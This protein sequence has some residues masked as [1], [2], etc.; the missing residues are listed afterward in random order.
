MFGVT[1]SPYLLSATILHHLNNYKNDETADLLRNSFYVDNCIVSVQSR[2]KMEHFM[3]EAKRIMLEG[4]FELRCWVT[5]PVIS[6]EEVVTTSI[7]G[8]MWDPR[9]D[10]LFSKPM[11]PKSEITKR[12]LL[13]VA[14]S[15][16]DLLGFL[17]PVT[18]VPRQIIQKCWIMNLSWDQT[19][20][21]DLVKTF[22]EWLHQLDILNMCRIPRR[23][24]R[25][26]LSLTNNSLHIFCD[27]SQTAY[28]CCIFLRTEYQGEVDMQLVMAKSR[29]AST[30]A[31]T[32][33]RL[34]LTAALIA[35]RLS[36]E[37]KSS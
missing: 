21:G 35:A 8:P 24:S 19:L 6:D 22:K 3:K 30:K 37:V 10:E 27:G 12:Y 31:I 17:C 28:A 13:S 2:E 20:V 15:I 32:I 1:T 18:I 4:K 25:F 5:G 11:S 29:V 34:E 9:P 23:L 26:N 36:T 7:L 33:P 16:F 14:Q